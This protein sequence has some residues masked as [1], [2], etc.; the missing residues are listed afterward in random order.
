MGLVAVLGIDRRSPRVLGV[1]GG[2]VAVVPGGEH[3]AAAAGGRIVR[4][5]GAVGRGSGLGSGAAR[6]AP[7]AVE[8]R[9]NRARQADRRRRVARRTPHLDGD[10][11]PDVLRRRVP[12]VFPA[13]HGD[14]PVRA[15]DPHA[16]RHDAGL[17]LLRPVRPIGRHRQGAVVPEGQGRGPPVEHIPRPRRFRG[18]CRARPFVRAGAAVPAGH[19]T[20]R[21]GDELALRDARAGR[22]LL[23][24]DLDAD[25]G[26]VRPVRRRPAD[27]FARRA[28][29][30][31]ARGRRVCARWRCCS[32]RPCDRATWR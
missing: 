3:P 29:G 15:S 2:A 26:G 12:A 5:G 4:P 16:D 30:R 31:P 27:P 18:L 28:R 13:L 24:P 10:D 17:R 21:P 22:F 23:R 6:M 11:A 14:R 32:G 9:R 7:S 8:R 20:G 1:A 25:A 19:A